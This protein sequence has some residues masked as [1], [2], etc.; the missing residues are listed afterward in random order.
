MF[1][2]FFQL[3]LHYLR[4]IFWHTYNS[5]CDRYLLHVPGPC[6]GFLDNPI[7]T[8][9]RKSAYTDTLSKVC[10]AWC[11]AAVVGHSKWCLLIWFCS[12]DK[13]RAIG[14]VEGDRG[15][16]PW[17]GNKDPSQPPIHHTTKEVIW[18]INQYVNHA[19][20]L[21]LT[22]NCNSKIFSRTKK[23]HFWKHKLIFDIFHRVPVWFAL[24]KK[25]R[26]RENGKAK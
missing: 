23:W 13:L 12:F 15:K 17:R 9:A 20:Q 6:S 1:A 7:L 5:F 24:G 10:F 26:H 22:D 18:Y 3:W 8:D 11:P 25:G 16:H 19:D 2:T 4:H 21:Q 14:S